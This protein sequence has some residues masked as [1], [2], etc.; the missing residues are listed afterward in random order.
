Y[1]VGWLIGVAQAALV[2]HALGL[3]A[4]LVTATIIEALWSAVRFATFF[5][6]A[7]LGTL[8]GASAAAFRSFGFSAGAGLAFT[9]VRR[10]CQ[11]VW[12]G[13]GVIVLL[14]L[15]PRRGPAVPPAAA[16]AGDPRLMS[17]VGLG[18]ES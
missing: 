10:A 12:I 2:L 3:R 4:A 17:R 15:R 14:A 1:F 7:S 11:A 8:E 18:G 16:V 13:V 9:L 5:V 6:P